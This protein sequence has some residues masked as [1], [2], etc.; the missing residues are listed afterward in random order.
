MLARINTLEKSVQEQKDALEL[1][2]MK[3]EEERRDKA[4]ELAHK[5]AEMADMRQKMEDMALEF[6]PSRTLSP[7]ARRPDPMLSLSLSMSAA[8]EPHSPASV[9]SLPNWQV[10]C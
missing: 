6:G 10:I 3:L 8:P 1:S 7:P 4:Q 2:R 9:H 5:D